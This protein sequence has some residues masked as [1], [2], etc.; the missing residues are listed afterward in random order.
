M[1]DSIEEYAKLRKELQT[2]VELRKLGIKKEDING[3]RRVQAGYSQGEMIICD[4]T[5]QVRLKDGSEHI[6]PLH[7]M[8][9]GTV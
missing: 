3:K 1:D 7:L 6:V 5:C 4:K 2:Y 9:G 8:Y